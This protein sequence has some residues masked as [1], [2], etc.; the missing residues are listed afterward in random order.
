[1]AYIALTYSTLL[2]SQ[3]TDAHW[4]QDFS[5]FQGRLPNLVHTCRLGQT[6]PNDELELGID[7]VR[8]KSSVSQQGRNYSPLVQGGQIGSCS[9]FSPITIPNSIDR[10]G[11]APRTT[12]F[13]EKL[14]QLNGR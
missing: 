9:E 3:G 2:S 10:D 4:S 7:A 6:D 11:F 13:T 1:M 8:P 5:C 14:N 12:I